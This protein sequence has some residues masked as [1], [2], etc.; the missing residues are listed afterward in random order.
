MPYADMLP[1]DPR[2]ESRGG[3]VRAIAAVFRFAVEQLV[4]MGLTAAI[5][6]ATRSGVLPLLPLTAVVE[7]EVG[8][9]ALLLGCA[10]ALVASTTF[11]RISFGIRAFFTTAVAAIV[12]AAPF[13]LA[14]AGLTLGLPPR[15]FDTLGTFAYLGFFLVIGLLIGGCWSV[16]VAAFRDAQ[17]R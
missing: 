1:G 8:N 6:L 7:R 10:A 14:R 2:R 11:S 3:A 17:A 13:I 9:F 12:L 4:P 16:V 15:Q 5:N